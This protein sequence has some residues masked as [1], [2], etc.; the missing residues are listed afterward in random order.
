MGHPFR[1][2]HSVLDRHLCETHGNLGQSSKSK[3][4]SR[5][6]AGLSLDASL[7]D[8]YLEISPAFT[9]IFWLSFP[10]WSVTLMFAERLGSPMISIFLVGDWPIRSYQYYDLNI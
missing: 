2:L 7:D 5:D 6:S 3:G 9:W 4:R 1:V 8:T 10:V